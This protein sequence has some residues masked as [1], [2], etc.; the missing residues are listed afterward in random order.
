[1]QQNY[2]AT[3]I[4]CNVKEEINVLDAGL[5]KTLMNVYMIMCMDRKE[6]AHD[7]RH[8]QG[9]V[10]IRVEENNRSPFSHRR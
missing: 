4:S 5:E 3:S 10:S 8:I 9:I 2:N 1:M 7:S 6:K